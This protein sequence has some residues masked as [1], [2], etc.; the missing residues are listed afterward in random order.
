MKNEFPLVYA[1][2]KAGKCRTITDAAIAAGL[3]KPRTRLHELKN[4]FE[5]ASGFEQT[6]FLR[7]L[8][9]KIAPSSATGTTGSMIAINERLSPAA[10]H[11]IEEIIAKR[12]LK[13]GD[14]MAEMGFP[15]LNASLGRALRRGDRLQPNVIAALQKWLAANAAI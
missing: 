12:R 13:V 4:A 10:K 15:K 9:A 7:W 1:D 2:L 6:E 3:K 8:A 11:R 14:V 5:K